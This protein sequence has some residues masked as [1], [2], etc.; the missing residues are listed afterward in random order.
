MDKNFHL[1]N[2]YNLYYFLYIYL[3]FLIIYNNHNI[4]YLILNYKLILNHLTLSL[5]K[6][7]EKKKESNDK[8][9]NLVL[10]TKTL[11]SKEWPKVTLA[12]IKFG[13]IL[14]IPEFTAPYPIALNLDT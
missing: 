12:S 6:I 8:I 13:G 10:L 11:F 1:I 4:I 3:F 14:N 7:F 5:I 2:L 9:N